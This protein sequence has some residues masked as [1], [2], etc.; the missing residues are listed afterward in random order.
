MKKNLFLS[1]SVVTLMLLVQVAPVFAASGKAYISKYHYYTDSSRI[2]ASYYYISNVTGAN[3][4]VAIKLF[5][6][7]LAGEIPPVFL[8]DSG[9]S[10]TTGFITAVDVLNYD[11]S[12]TNSTATFDLAPYTTGQIKIYSPTSTEGGNGHGVIEWTQDSEA[13][14]GIVAHGLLQYGAAAF[15]TSIPSFHS[16][17]INGGNPF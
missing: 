12:G 11:E 15:N 10:S 6:N 3:I 2:W 5:R 13:P 1:V 4:H 9:N 17:M 16:I 7:P 8:K 14:V